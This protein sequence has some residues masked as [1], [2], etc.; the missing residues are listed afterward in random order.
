MS[1]PSSSTPYR[2]V[3]A[4]PQDPRAPAQYPYQQQQPQQPSTSS[5]SAFAYAQQQ[6]QI[7]ASRQAQPQPTS[8][9]RR[10][11]STYLPPPPADRLKGIP[12]QH[13][14]R[15]SPLSD[16]PHSIEELAKIAR[17][18]NYDRGGDLKQD[19]R[20]AEVFL[21]EGRRDLE[22]GDLEW[23]F[24][25]FARAATLVLEKIPTNAHYHEIKESHRKKIS[26]NG[27]V[28]LDNMDQIKPKLVDQYELWR[29][30]QRNPAAKPELDMP[31]ILNAMVARDNEELAI[32][33]QAYKM[34]RM[35]LKEA[36]AARRAQA[37]EEDDDDDEEEEVVARRAEEPKRPPDAA[38]QQAVYDAAARQ[39]YEDT[40]RRQEDA[41]RRETEDTR[42]REA[43]EAVA[44]RR[45]AEQIKQREMEESIRRGAETV[46]RM[47]AENAKRREAEERGRIAEIERRKREA[48]EQGRR[49]E[50]DIA[51]RRQTEESTARA[52]AEAEAAA[53]RAREEEDHRRQ[54]EEAQRREMVEMQRQQQQLEENKR[55]EESRRREFEEARRRE[56]EEARRQEAEE[57]R[58]REVE[59]ARRQEA[60]EAKRREF[61]EAKR[62]EFEEAKRREFEEAKRR[63]FEEARRR[64]ADE[65]RRREQEGIAQR[66]REAE[67]EARQSRLQ[68]NVPSPAHNFAS[69]S[70]SGSSRT[71]QGTTRQQQDGL[72]V[73]PLESPTR[74]DA[75]DPRSG[76]HHPQPQRAIQERAPRRSNTFQAPITTT[77]PP[78]KDVASPWAGMTQHQ[79]SQG[80]APSLQSMFSVPITAPPTGL[81]FSPNHPEGP[82]MKNMPTSPDRPPAHIRHIWEM[83]GFGAQLPDKPK[84]KPSQDDSR[85]LRPEEVRDRDAAVT[86]FQTELKNIHVPGEIITRFMHVAAV[87]TARNKETCGLLMGRWEGQEYK[88]VTLLIP[89]QRAT[90]D[91]CTMEGEELVSDFA[92]KRKMMTLG[93][94]H[95]HPTQSCFMSSLDLHTHASFQCMLPEFFA[96][97]VAPTQFPNCGVF[98]LTDPPGLKTILKCPDK[99]SFHPHGDLPI[100]TDADKGHVI[101]KTEDALEIVDLR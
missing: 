80:Y 44:R 32:R 47:E 34:K 83:Q 85:I 101:W 35:A 82:S 18:D 58:R 39:A 75:L 51:R 62:R 36:E 81:L 4:Q 66:Q 54:R 91:T 7:Y 50:E 63:E 90:S 55:I 71:S 84:P 2:Y 29:Q 94:I 38:R 3:P 52:A 64:E 97:V 89:R 53:R 5:A 68:V 100:Y 42:R 26:A 9:P 65:A 28:C 6:Q 88:V 98:R 76:R 56:V 72:P 60:E 93:W 31:R 74:P 92:E 17:Q 40:R 25:H 11:P 33:A 95:T 23:A 99:S 30:R 16:R 27:N 21:A 41:K 96:I 37:E 15:P 46:R 1:T 43:E 59:E 14:K 20:Y 10:H 77:S 69:S 22:A 19:L 67:A 12:T 86:V 70:P 49:R 8:A 45:E 61:E 79:R 48:E 13:P 87:N 57:A 78:P 73:L 24:V